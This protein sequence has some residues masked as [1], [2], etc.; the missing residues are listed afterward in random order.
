MSNVV[1]RKIGEHKG[2]P[3][4]YLEGQK[5]ATQGIAPG[6]RF[7][8]MKKQDQICLSFC[9]D[10]E[11]KVSRRKQKDGYLPVMDIRADAIESVFGQAERIRAIIKP[12]EI[13]ITIHHRELAEKE[14]LE[15]LIR[16]LCNNEPLDMG[17]L[18][19]GGGVLD[20][21]LHNGLNLANI[22]T[23]LSF[24]VE[25]EG[26]YLDASQRN[27]PV[28]DKSSIAIEAPMQD[29]ETYKLPKVDILA[30]GIPCVGASLAGRSS[31]KLSRAEEHETAG[32]LFVAFLNIIMATQPSIIVLENV[33]PYQTTASM[34][35]I[36]QVLSEIGYKVHETILDGNQMGALEA[37]KRLCVVAI[38]DGLDGFDI[39][40]IEPLRTKESCLND[41]MEFIPDDSPRWKVLDYLDSK[42][43]R[44]IA[45]G[46][47]FKR[48]LL[49][50]NEN[51]CGTI[52]RGYSKLRS[53]EPFIR[54]L[55]T[56]K[57]RIFTP[58]E[59]ARV[60]TIP[61]YL[62]NGVSDTVAHE[63]LGQSVIHCSF[64]AVGKT[65]GDAINFNLSEKAVAA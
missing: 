3:R 46:K 49:T 28:W 57:Q 13:I 17:S 40:N 64:I 34:T 8:L 56:G 65:I 14:R 54:H 2:K 22:A 32:S 19:H 5:L 47:G 16:K 29:V 26:K 9:D 60:K 55:S 10:G 21:A 25:I 43:K 36:R 59:H 42:E 45:S 44:D 20:H 35:V 12:D 53:T 39:N 33:P 41:V 61:E 4:I 15:R 50:G 6:M 63:I 37:R 38:T 7:R 11:R 52:G 48:Q 27:N 18:A 1:Y 23:R 30:S 58:R 62:I 31:N 24:A 51:S